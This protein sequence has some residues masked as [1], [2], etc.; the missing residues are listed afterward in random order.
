LMRLQAVL[1]GWFS[2]QID[3]DEYTMNSDIGAL[4]IAIVGVVGTLSASIISQILAARARREELETQR[5]QRRDEFD[6]DQARG[7]L[8]TQRQ[9]T[10]DFILATDSAHGLL[11]NVATRSI[12]QSELKQAARDAV[13]DSSLYSIRERMLIVVPAKVAYAAEKTFHSIIEIRDAVASGSAL[14]SPPYR[15]AYSVYAKAI[16]GLRQ[17]ARESFGVSSL[18]LR[19]IEEI[20]ADRLARRSQ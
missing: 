2:T 20:E 3:E 11:R 14:N 7:E 6:R 1:Y 18:D 4:I 16:W 15:D 12:D 8:E 10:V 9:T 13:G 19:E 17:A 5:L